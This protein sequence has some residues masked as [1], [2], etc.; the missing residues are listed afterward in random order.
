MTAGQLRRLIDGVPDAALVRVTLEGG[1]TIAIG[2][3][4]VD[5][6]G[7]VLT[8]HPRPMRRP[9]ANEPRLPP[10]ERPFPRRSKR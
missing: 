1:D 4:G 8:E 2:T 6:S 3:G 10:P 7:V 9:E 5:A